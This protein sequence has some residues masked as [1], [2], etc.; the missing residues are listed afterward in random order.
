VIYN[1]VEYVRAQMPTETVYVNGRNS[2]S[3]DRCLL[4]NEGGGSEQP[5]TKFDRATVQVIARDVDSPKARKLAYAVL[6]LLTN[7]FG[8]ILPQAVV[9]GVTYAAVVTGQ[10]SAIQLPYP[11]G[12]D[13]DGRYEFSNNYQVI[14]ER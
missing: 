12:P 6:V 7:R 3:P 8:L 4:L 9:D 10:I 14:M 2:P 13:D 11:L 1:L 5:W